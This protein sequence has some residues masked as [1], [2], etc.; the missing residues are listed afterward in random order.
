MSRQAPASG[1][2]LGRINMLQAGLSRD[3]AD[4]LLLLLSSVLVL[5]PHASHLPLWISAACTAT[6]GWRAFIT[7]MGKRMPS[8]WILLPIAALAIIAVGRTSAAFLGR[9]SGVGMLV[10]LLAFKLLEMHAKRDAY[11]VMFLSFFLILTNFLYSQSIGTALMMVAA[12]IAILTA[13][14]SLQYANRVPPLGQRLRLAMRIFLPA[15]PLTLV[16]FVL[17]PRIS[18]PLWGLATD[19][20]GSKSG[21]SD[22]MAPGDVSH[23]ALSD[24]IAFRVKFSDPVPQNRQLYWRGPV[25]GA[26]D[27]RTWTILQRNAQ[28]RALD[29][30]LTITLRGAPVRHQVTL[31]PTGQH[32]LYAL[33]LPKAAPFIQGS[34]TGFT[35]DLQLVSGKTIGKRVR[36]DVVSA[37]D[38]QLQADESLADMQQ[39]LELPAGMNPRTLAFAKTLQGPSGRNADQAQQITKVLQHFRRETFRYTLEPPLLGKHEIDEFLFDTK[40][41]FCEH[42]SGAFAVLM[43]A[44]GIPARVVT[45][46]QGGEIN[47][48]DGIM[49]VRQSDAHAWA[50][51]WLDNRGWLRIDPTGAVAPERV[52]KNLASAIPGRGFGQFFGLN[53]NRFMNLEPGKD[54]LFAKLRNNWGAVTNAW[55]QWVLDYNPERQKNLIESLGI[56]NANWRTLVLLM[57]GIGSLAVALVFLPM[58]LQ[59]RK[60]DPVNALYFALCQRMARR[61]LARAAHEGPRSYG[62]RLA[63]ALSTEAPEKQAAIGQFLAVYEAA[64]YA[65][66]GTTQAASSKERA[67]ISTLQS[68]LTRCR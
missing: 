20:Q 33:E 53:V 65:G 17:F 18:G 1:A 32:W 13:Q 36:Y 8:P 12:V 52:E 35:P 14:V 29:R 23:L 59:R 27:G 2:L 26:Y 45:G 67:T 22:S 24:E 38:F 61:G 25:L 58:L 34:R 44:M 49:A 51:V 28:R 50:E 41:G 54:S 63:L 15:L 55:N 16:L 39:W 9:E 37:L 19:A 42:Y 47:P 60:R 11:A 57:I 56:G 62:A 68:L 31:E 64:K 48:V 46:Y 3:K 5:A 30:T 66:E 40:A 21:M 7:F 10:L 4:T 43:R 6:L